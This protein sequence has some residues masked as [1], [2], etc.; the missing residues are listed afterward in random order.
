MTGR[1]QSEEPLTAGLAPALDE[2][3]PIRVVVVRQ[4]FA[5]SDVARRAYPDDALLDVDVTVGAA[6]VVDEP[7]DV[8]ADARVDHRAVGQLEAPDLAAFDVAALAPEAFPVRDA[9][10]GVVDDACV[11]RKAGRGEHAPA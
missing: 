4:L 1:G 2:G 11:L 7:R 8:A 5:L 10:A 6:R 3:F 9:L